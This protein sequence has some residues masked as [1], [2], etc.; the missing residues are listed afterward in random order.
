MI[1]R[2]LPFC[3][4][5]CLLGLACISPAR[6]ERINGPTMNACLLQEAG[7][8]RLRNL[9]DFQINITFC[10][11]KRDSDDCAAGRIGGTTMAARSSRYLL[12][13]VLQTHYLVCRAPYQASPAD[14][15]WL[16][17]GLQGRCQASRAPKAKRP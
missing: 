4:S 5:F 16:N 15:R 7:G 10:Q 9:C 3:L 11:V 1:L 6:A 17:A 13:D 14:T 2:P 8:Q 12:D